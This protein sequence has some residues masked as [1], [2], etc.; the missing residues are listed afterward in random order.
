MLVDLQ[1]VP[2]AV[3]EIQKESQ[4]QAVTVTFDVGTL[5]KAKLF[6][7]HVSCSVPILA[8]AK[9]S[10]SGFSLFGKKK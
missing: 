7:V 10:S 3:A 2:A 8:T 1:L 6:V 4:Q 9:K 5:T